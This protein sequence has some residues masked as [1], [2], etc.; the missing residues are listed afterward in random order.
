MP[1]A[2]C[3]ILQEI[4]IPTMKKL[5]LLSIFLISFS[6][7][8]SA[9]PKRQMRAVWIATMTNI[10]W[11]SVR[12]LAVDIQKKEMIKMLDEFQANKIN[13]IFYQIRP[14]S[15]A[16]YKS[17][18]EPFSMWLSGKQ[19]FPTDPFYDP[20]E[21]VLE[22]AHK[23][24]IEV[25]VWLNP[26]R[27]VNAKNISQ[28]HPSHIFFK[29]RDWFV[30]YG[31]IYYFDPG[32]KE[33][34][35]YLDK[36]VKDIVKRY[37]IDAIHF[38]DYFY[39]YPIAGAEFPDQASFKKDP[40]GFSPRHKGDWRRDNV[41]LVIR[42]LSKTIRTTKPWVKFGIS[43]FGIWRHKG[44]DPRGSNTQIGLAN[45]DD[46]YA[47]ILKWIKEGT[48]DYVAPQ[49]Y[50]AIGKKNT[51]Y[52]DVVKWWNDNTHS[53]NLYTGLF[54]T[55]LNDYKSVA[56]RTPNEII[57]QIQFNKNFPNVKGVAFYSA[58]YFMR[59]LQSLNTSLKQ[60][61]FT[62]YAIVPLTPNV[63]GEPSAQPKQIK[64][65]T[66]DN[67][68]KLSWDAV[69]EDEGKAVA[70]YVVYMMKGKDIVNTENPNNIIA[71]TQNTELDINEFTLGLIGS[72]TF[73]V[74]SIN[75]YSQESP[76][77]TILVER[78]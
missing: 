44:N 78:F 67:N 60:S 23:R 46:L 29:E 4:S 75:K 53:C 61:E 38:D 57:R 51:D 1:N 50:W 19:G 64:I 14:C 65:T 24:C 33:T 43:P 72:Y 76:V 34:R 49:I 62:N 2:L 63:L 69:C 22:E 9:T 25:H 73:T 66:K 3:V 47:D 41:T 71:V 35:N 39:P 40:R 20:L 74:T 5:L 48:I 68:R 13:A 8:Y 30:R 16:F 36:I 15:D 12:G 26:Y 6:Q 55:G 18:Y 32:L 11:P 10:D 37:D 7:G 45:Y 54:V 42:Q 52:K 21:F 28:L 77:K 70:Y 27:A 17:E 59:N 31:D 56:W 58:K